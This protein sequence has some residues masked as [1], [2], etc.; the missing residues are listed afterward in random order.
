MLQP[1]PVGS[2]PDDTL[3]AAKA[4]IPGGNT[5]IKLRDR[6]GT[7]FHDSLFEPLF[8]KRD[9]S[10]VTRWQDDLA[11]RDLLPKRHFVDGSYMGSQIALE[12]RKRHNIELVGPAK[13]NWHRHQVE[14][15]YDLSAFKIDWNGHFAICPQAKRVRDGGRHKPSW[16]VINSYKVLPD[17]LRQMQ[18]QPSVYEERHE[19]FPQA[20]TT[21]H[22]ANS[23]S[24]HEGRSD[25]GVV[26]AGTRSRGRDNRGRKLLRFR[27]Q[28]SCADAIEGCFAASNIAIRTGCWKAISAAA[29]TTLVMRG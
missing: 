28:R 20:G 25:A 9:A 27:K 3:N 29:S 18:C 26:P 17:R 12:S 21:P 23:V 15:G 6:L 1:Q 11:L 7:I 8:S 24:H 5:C 2:I 19:E 16:S 4:A 14:S 13:Q 10:H 22:H